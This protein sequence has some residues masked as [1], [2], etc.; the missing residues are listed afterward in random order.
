L[1]QIRKLNYN[2]PNI[3]GFSGKKLN[4]KKG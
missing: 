3:E 1:K 2:E 4:L